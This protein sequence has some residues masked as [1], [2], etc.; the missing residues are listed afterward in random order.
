MRCAG[1]QF[2][3]SG[4]GK[5]CHCRE[6]VHRSPA[7]RVRSRWRRPR[8]KGSRSVTDLYR[9][10]G[11]R[12]YL[13]GTVCLADVDLETGLLGPEQLTTALERYPDISCVI[14]VHFG[15]QTVAMRG[16]T[17]KPGVMDICEERNIAVVED[18]AHALP[19]QP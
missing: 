13:G 19:R 7:S 14:P 12:E 9:H 11:S 1:N 15:G 16:T 5:T 4:W 10:G 3:H 6:L 18:A 8:V 17:E 2:C